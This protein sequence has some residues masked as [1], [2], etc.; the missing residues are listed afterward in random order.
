MDRLRPLPS[1]ASAAEAEGRMSARHGH[2]T[3]GRFGE[4]LPYIDPMLKTP[5]R[6]ADHR[7]LHLVLD[8]LGLSFPKDSEPLLLYR[9][10]RHAVTAGWHADHEVPLVYETEAARDLQALFVRLA[11]TLQLARRLALAAL[12]AP[13]GCELHALGV[14][15]LGELRGREQ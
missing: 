11:R 15:L 1:P 12:A 9:A 10:H 14:A 2:H 4:R 6:P 5:M 8:D 7:C 3:D 13:E